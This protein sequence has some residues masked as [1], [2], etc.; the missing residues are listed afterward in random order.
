MREKN[1]KKKKTNGRKREK[2]VGEKKEAQVQTHTNTVED[3]FLDQA[4]QSR[5][6]NQ[7]LPEGTNPTKIRRDKGKR[8]K[9]FEGQIPRGVQPRK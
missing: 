9:S 3:K 8:T 1:K 5:K 7:E 6:K 2:G 4:H